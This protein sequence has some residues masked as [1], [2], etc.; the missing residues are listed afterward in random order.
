[1]RKKIVYIPENGGK[2]II[3]PNYLKSFYNFTTLYNMCDIFWPNTGPRIHIILCKCDLSKNT[4]K[5]CNI[6]KG[7][8]DKRINLVFFVVNLYVLVHV[9]LVVEG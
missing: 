3:K 5:H 1:L 7:E 2:S 6:K 9:V 8:Y 4:N